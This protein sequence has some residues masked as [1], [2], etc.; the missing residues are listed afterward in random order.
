MGEQR[1]DKTMEGVQVEMAGHL[2]DGM[3]GIAG[4]E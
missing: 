3:N 4:K 2:I 1:M